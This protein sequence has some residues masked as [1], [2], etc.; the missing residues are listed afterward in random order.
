M[1]KKCRNKKVKVCAN[2]TM[3][4][5]EVSR[6]RVDGLPNPE[7]A[8]IQENLTFFIN[9]LTQMQADGV[10]PGTKLRVTIETID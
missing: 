8:N 5:Y 3:S 2:A 6:H 4:V 10:K 1:S 7:F 9:L